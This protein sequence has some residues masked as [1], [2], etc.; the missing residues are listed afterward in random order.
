[1]AQDGEITAIPDSWSVNHATVASF[2]SMFKFSGGG[3]RGVNLLA[4][5]DAAGYQITWISNQDDTAIRAQYMALTDR[6]VTLNR[7]G[8][9]STISLDEKV[10][11]PLKAA[12]QEPYER[13]LIVVHLIGCHPHYSL[14]YP[15]GLEGSWESSSEDPVQDKLKELGRGRFVRNSRDHYDRA[16]L[17]QDGVIA[18]TLKLTQR[19][20]ASPNAFWCYLSDH[21][22]EVGNYADWDGH[23][24]T[25]PSGYRIPL[26]MWSRE[27]ARIGMAAGRSFRADWVDSMLLEAAGISW[28][29]EALQESLLS[30]KYRWKV[31]ESKAKFVR[32]HTVMEPLRVPQ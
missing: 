23:S 16:I 25:T 4:L 12:L 21:G 13:K 26:L 22:Q 17:Y 2:D 5:F 19:Y 7:L 20:A 14:R 30:S 10:L 1:M 8:G 28:K 24:N 27:K 29:G 32:Q 6:V 15:D 18:Q 9:R 31:P 3:E 11:E